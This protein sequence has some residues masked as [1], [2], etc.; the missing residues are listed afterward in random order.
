MRATERAELRHLQRMRQ[1]GAEQVALVVDED[2]GLVDQAPE[3]G[4]VH[5]AVAVALVFGA[6]GGGRLG[7]RRPRLCAQALA[8]GANGATTHGRQRRSR[9]RGSLWRGSPRRTRASG[10]GRTPARP[11]PR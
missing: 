7:W 3:R 9:R 2:L 11:R 1:P 6:P 10:A 4:A 5:D 8:Q